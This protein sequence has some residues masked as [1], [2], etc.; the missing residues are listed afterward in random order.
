MANWRAFQ[1]ANGNETYLNLDLAARMVAD[2]KGHTLIGFAHAQG[3]Y[4][5]VVQEAPGLVFERT[6][7]MP[8]EASSDRSDD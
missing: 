6:A 5:V 4:D 8:T 7:R 3:F 2:G 1:D